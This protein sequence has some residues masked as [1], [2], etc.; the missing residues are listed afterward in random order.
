[1]NDVFLVAK[2]EVTERL[3]SRVFLITNGAFLLL[4][5][6]GIFI[7]GPLSGDSETNLAVVD[8]PA[9]PIAEAVEQSGDVA[10]TVVP[11]RAAAEE[12]VRSS[13]AD[14]ALVAPGEL[15]VE[16]EVPGALERQLTGARQQL[17]IAQALAD[18]GVDADERAELMA[19][20]E[21]TV[22]SLEEGG[23]E[24]GPG[25]AVGAATVFFLYIQLI[26]YG[27]WVAQGVVEEKSSRIVEVLVATVSPRQ[28]LA[29]KIL[30]LGGLGMGTVAIVATIAA[31][32]LSVTDIFSVPPE[33]YRTLAIAVGWYILGYTL[34]ATIF[35]TAG[36]LVSRVED[37]SS[38]SMPGIILLIGSFFL[39]Q[40]AITDPFA[41][42]ATVAALLPFSAPMVQ[43]LLASIDALEPWMV[44]AGLASTVAA[45]ALLLPLAARIYTGGVLRTSGRLRVMEAWHSA[46]G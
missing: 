40:F 36:A 11:G 23:I 44:A 38:A 2:R 19:P 13:E 46:R 45:I 34:Y 42:V 32:G 41:P 24:F 33:A 21:L 30:G 20:P 7:G 22:T 12:A 29:G 43:P 31:I 3:R 4:I 8:G 27:Q 6:V 26:L 35:A 16:R 9:A 14:A 25:L 18:A 28:L 37:L 10:V 17:A 1:M 39:A 15:V 5:V